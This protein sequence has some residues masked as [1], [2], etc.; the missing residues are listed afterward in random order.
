[1]EFANEEF[2]LNNLYFIV[3]KNN[4]KILFKPNEIQ[5]L[6]N[7][8][9]ALRKMVLKA[10]Q[11]GISTGEIVKQFDYTIFNPNV[12]S[13]ILAHEQ[14]AITK[15]FRIV[16]R[17][18]DFLDPKHKP[19]V[20]RGGGS[21]YELYFPEINSRIYCD[22]ESRGDTISWL[23][24]SEAAFMKD[25][26]KLKS[27]LQAVPINTGRVTIETTPNGIN[28]YF[29]EEWN[30]ANSIYS[31]MFFPWFLFSQYQ[32]PAPKGMVI[33]EE[34]E[35]LIKK[36][37]KLF[38]V[39][40]TKEQLMFRRYKKSELKVN[41]A[42]VV[43]VTFEQEYPEDDQSCFLSSGDAVFDLIQIKKM[44]L[45][46]K[47]PTKDKDGLKIYEPINK[48]KLY[49]IGADTAEGVGGDFSVGVCI[50]VTD[51][52]IAAKLR[53]Q[54]KPSDFAVKLNE[55]GDLYTGPQYNAPLMAVERNNHGHAVILK[56]NE[57]LC[58]SNLFVHND[59]KLGW[60]T[61]MVTRPIMI[62]TFKDAV[63]ENHLEIRDKDIL[64]ECMTFIN[65]DGKLEAASG[66]HD[67]CIIATAI[68]L[69]LALQNVSFDLYENIDQ[70]IRM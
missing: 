1:M 48:A 14:G 17:C 69:Q 62:N 35:L 22:L 70:R 45:E 27:T 32:L 42:D 19:R 49:V 38:N 9:P 43:R 25:S 46:A 8:N 15:L 37:K 28:N 2:R 20:D 40:I 66:K 5:T 23:H 53:G 51:M 67:D 26:S 7:K 16:K 65:D 4:N 52:R 54:F 21:K 24:V 47:D 59:E 41:L 64:K 33:T 3:D 61:D 36:S 44:L 31:K 55:L 30:D 50:N 56:L 18:Y 68:A 29:Y 13:V 60:K 63:E 11:F 39:E 6:V 58:Y 34:E 12:T 57:D 10:R